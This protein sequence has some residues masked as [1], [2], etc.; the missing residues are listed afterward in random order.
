[1]LSPVDLSLINGP[2]PVTA[3]VAGVLA[4]V[5]LAVRTNRTWWTRTVPVV[6]LTCAAVTAGLKVLVDQE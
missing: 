1:M 3:T 5:A 6:V 2:I 4:L